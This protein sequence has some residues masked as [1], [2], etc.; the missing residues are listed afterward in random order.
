MDF[1][2]LSEEKKTVG[3][4]ITTSYTR[5]SIIN[6]LQ[7]DTLH[8]KILPLSISSIYN[9]DEKKIENTF[10]VTTQWLFT[11]IDGNKLV[12]ISNQKVQFNYGTLQLPYAYTGLGRTNNY[13]E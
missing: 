2:V 10:G 4:V 8:L 9:E 11:D 5:T 13:L 1:M 7:F 6:N 3:N 12:K